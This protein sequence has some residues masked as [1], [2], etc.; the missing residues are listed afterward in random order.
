[1]GTRTRLAIIASVVAVIVAA[2]ASLLIAGAA[3]TNDGPDLGTVKGPGLAQVKAAVAKYHTTDAALNAEY[4]LVPGLDQCFE[5]PG[6]GA[7]GIHYINTN[8]LD[9]NL[10]A[11]QPEALVYQQL[12]NGKLHLGA[13]EYIVPQAPWDADHPLDAQGNRE[14]PQISGLTSEP[15]PLHLNAGLGVYVLH[16]WIFTANPA[17]TFK[18]WN[19]NVSCLPG[20]GHMHSMP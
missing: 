14:L 15:L 18:D 7:M 3:G 13:V 16:A 2:G 11:S 9:E 17:G 10:N 20:T 4:G 19:P 12:P 6:T 1:M 8:L 5:Q